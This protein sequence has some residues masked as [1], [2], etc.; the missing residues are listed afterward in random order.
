MRQ[1]AALTQAEFAKMAKVSPRAQFNYEKGESFPDL[2]Y[3]QNLANSGF[4]IVYI[5][6]GEFHQE[7]MS[8]IERLLLTEFRKANNAKKAAIMAVSR[9]EESDLEI[10]SSQKDSEPQPVK[11]LKNS[12]RLSSLL[13]KQINQFSDS[14]SRYFWFYKSKDDDKK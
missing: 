2:N 1:Q 7:N 14:N 4:D 6:T 8:D 11:E 12:K 3:L 5:L 9:S 10:L 13:A